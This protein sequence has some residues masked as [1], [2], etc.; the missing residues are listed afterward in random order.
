M[1]NKVQLI[2]TE[3]NDQMIP[4]LYLEKRKWKKYKKFTPKNKYIEETKTIKWRTK[5]NL[6][7]DNKK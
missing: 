5:L 1:K 4:Y 6:N 3:D 7:K 2:D